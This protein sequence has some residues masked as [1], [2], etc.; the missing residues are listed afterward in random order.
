MHCAIFTIWNIGEW[1]IVFW[2]SHY[3]WACRHYSRIIITSTCSLNCATINT[4]INAYC[5]SFRVIEFRSSIPIRYFIISRFNCLSISRFHIIIFIWIFA[6]S[7]KHIDTISIKGCLF[8]TALTHDN[9]Y[10]NC[11]YTLA[12]RFLFSYTPSRSAA[13]SRHRSCPHDNINIS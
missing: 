13:Q 5:A 10:I 2:S 12:L 7:S 6:H 8:Q 9:L 1:L 11:R 3:S 4:T